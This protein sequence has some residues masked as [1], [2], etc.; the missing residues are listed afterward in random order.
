[1]NTLEI[2]FVKLVGVDTT[3]D[4]L[5]LDFKDDVKNHI[6]TIHAGA[7]F[8]LAETKS[9][10]HLQKLFPQLESKVIPLLRES[11]IKYKQPAKEK[12][13]AF[14]KCSE[15]SVKKFSEQFEKKGRGSILVEVEIKDINEVVTA[16]ATF[17]WFVQSL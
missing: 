7:Q 4:E 2:P 1:M 11:H 3:N 10:M 6:Q 12:I 15:E 14:A 5:F 9:G 13:F 17:N 8:T 16:V